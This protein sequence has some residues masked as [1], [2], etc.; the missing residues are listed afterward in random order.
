[1]WNV[2]DCMWPEF[3]QHIEI[4]PTIRL[5]LNRMSIKIFLS[6]HEDGERELCGTSQYSLILRNSRPAGRG[7]SG[8]SMSGL[9]IPQFHHLP[10]PLRHHLMH[11]PVGSAAGGRMARIS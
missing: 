10:R 4:L 9:S 3:Y 7:N 8:R 11:C 2:V 6:E 1:M 5:G